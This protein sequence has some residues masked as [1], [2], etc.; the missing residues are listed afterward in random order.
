MAERTLCRLMFVAFCLLPTLV[1]AGWS[2]AVCSSPYR[3]AKR[4]ELEQQFANQTGLRISLEKLR[5]LRSGVMEL[6]QVELRDA[7]DQVIATADGVSVQWQEQWEVRIEELTM[8]RDD[9]ALIWDSLDHRVLRSINL[10]ENRWQLAADLATVYCG[11][12]RA[13]TATEPLKNLRLSLQV[14]GPLRSCE[15]EFSCVGNSVERLPPPIQAV[16]VQDQSK[17][18]THVKMSARHADGVPARLLSRDLQQL[19]G[20]SC[21]FYGEVHAQRSADGWMAQIKDAELRPIELARWAPPQTPLSGEAVVQVGK[22]QLLDGRLDIAEGRLVSP[23]G[24][25]HPAA[26]EELAVC[27]HLEQA[28]RPD[29]QS[30]LDYRNLDVAFRLDSFGLAL[31]GK[32]GEGAVMVDPQGATLLRS[33]PI[34]AHHTRVL[35]GLS[36]SGADHETLGRR[37][38]S[39]VTRAVATV[40]PATTTR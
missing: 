13:K 8:H 21:R 33:R 16:I 11:L 9:V 14:A 38:P 40:D 39:P 15:L 22:A 19:A 12:K 35:Y 4:R 30:L 32:I 28:A 7:G 10:R 31:E 36:R 29:R 5:R 2:I 27:L 25:V 23:G 24:V 6:G 37:A 20:E 1:V 17:G 34:Y 3:A 18:V 26:L